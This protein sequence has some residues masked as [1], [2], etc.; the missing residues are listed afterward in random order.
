MSNLI[1]VEINGKNQGLISKGA[2]SP[3]SIG[4]AYVHN[5]DNEI[6]AQSFKYGFSNPTNAENR[7]TMG[8]G[9]SKPFVF[10]KMIDKSSPLLYQSL[11]QGETLT[12]VVLKA[13]RTSYLGKKE[14]FLKISLVDAKILYINL[15]N[16]KETIYLSYKTMEIEHVIA[17][18]ISKVEWKNGPLVFDKEM[19][20]RIV[21]NAKENY[22]VTNDYLEE[23]VPYLGNLGEVAAF[24]VYKTLYNNDFNKKHMFIKNPVMSN[25]DFAL[26]IWNEEKGKTRF[27]S[28]TSRRAKTLLRKVMIPA[29]IAAFVFETGVAVGSVLNATYDELTEGF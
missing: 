19:F 29:T 28:S 18:T 6:L 2:T 8:Q 16:H 12:N 17:N 24:A 7:R 13:Y 27:K 3:E 5:H 25:S 21:F 1:F 22:K 4:N 20:D 23:L 14:N 9:R 15:D 10:S 26:Q 11:T